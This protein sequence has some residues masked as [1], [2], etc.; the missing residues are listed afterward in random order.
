MSS[1]FGSFSEFYVPNPPKHMMYEF[2][3]MDHCCFGGCTPI[4]C[5]CCARTPFGHNRNCPEGPLYKLEARAEELYQPKH[6]KVSPCLERW[7]EAESGKY[8]PRCCRF[9]KSCSVE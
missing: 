2:D 4:P 5:G 3:Y 7:P 6:M 9:P 1:L 8:D